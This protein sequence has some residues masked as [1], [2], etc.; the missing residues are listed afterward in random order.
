MNLGAI[1]QYEAVKERL[2]F[3]VEQK[4][5]LEVSKTNSTRLS[6]R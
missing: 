4:T 5:D 3:L 1:A 6:P 2:D